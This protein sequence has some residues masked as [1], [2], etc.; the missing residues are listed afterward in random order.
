MRAGELKNRI[1][2]EFLSL[3]QD[4]ITGDITE[5]WAVQGSY[6]ADIYPMSVKDQ[7][8]SD[9]SQSTSKTICKIRYSSE[10]ANITSECRVVFKG[11]YYKL[12]GDPYPDNEGGLNWLTLNLTEGKRTWP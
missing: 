5:E 9:A 1:T 2:V 10:S 12:N 4:E 3:I 7:I 11:K 8:I 6:W